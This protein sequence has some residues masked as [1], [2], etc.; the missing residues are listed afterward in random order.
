MRSAFRQRGFTGENSVPQIKKRVD[1]GEI[2]LPWIHVVGEDRIGLIIVR[3]DVFDFRFRRL[4]VSN[5]LD[6]AHS[7]QTVIVGKISIRSWR[8]ESTSLQLRTSRIVP[9]SHVR[10]SG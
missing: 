9:N 2:C 6:P 10:S 4:V 5:G 1:F 8:L 3:I 7:R